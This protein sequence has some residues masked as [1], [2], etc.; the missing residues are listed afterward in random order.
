VQISD[1]D[2]LVN[3]EAGGNTGFAFELLLPEQ[4]TVSTWEAF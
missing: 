3:D 4:R 1:A 2:D